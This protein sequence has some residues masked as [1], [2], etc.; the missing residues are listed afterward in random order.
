MSEHWRYEV[1]IPATHNLSDTQRKEILELTHAHGYRPVQG[2]RTLPSDE[3]Q[4]ATLN[5]MDMTVEWLGELGG[6]LQLHKGPDDW[7]MEIEMSLPN[8]PGHY[9]HRDSLSAFN[10]LILYVGDYNYRYED[11]P[12]ERLQ[13]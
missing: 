7:P 8:A 3:W 2:F 6:L 13:I 10:E 11:E 5:S 12:E 1:W 9:E 4:E